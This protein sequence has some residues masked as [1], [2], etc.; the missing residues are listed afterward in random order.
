[1]GPRRK[2]DAVSFCAM[3]RRL[4]FIV[5]LFVLAAAPHLAAAHAVLVDTAPHDGAVLQHAPDALTLRFN[6]PVNPIAVRLFGP[7][8]DAVALPT[9]PRAVD[10]EIR[11]PLPTDLPSGAYLVSFRV[12]SADAHPIGGSF[13]FAIGTADASTSL[14][15]DDKA[16]RED[17]W[18]FATMMNRFVGLLALLAAAG[19]GLCLAL[20]FRG[21]APPGSPIARQI[22]L[23]GAVAIAAS[24]LALGLTGGWLLAGPAASLLDSSTWRLGSAT[25]IGRRAA[26]SILGL[27]LLAAGLARPQRAWGRYLCIA[28][29]LVATCS[30]ALSGHA[31]ALK[32]S[33]PTQAALALHATA[34]AF[35]IGSLGPLRAVVRQMPPREAA[36][37]LH[38]FS[39]LAIPAVALLAFAG[40][41]I[42]IAQIR[43]FDALLD[44]AYGWILLLKL[45]FV[46]M[47]LVLAA[48]NWRTLTPMLAAGNAA[49]IQ[50]LRAAIRT[51]FGFAAVVLL[52]TAILAHTAPGIPAPKD[53]HGHHEAGP[54]VAIT[55]ES[56]GRSLA[57]SV[58][59]ASVGANRIEGRIAGT[60]GALIRP[61]EVHVEFALPE[62]GI[63]PLRWKARIT[64]DG[65]AQLNSVSLPR[66]GLWQARVE[67]LISD[68]EKAVFITAIPIR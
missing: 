59:P 68:F 35:W 48:R 43:T 12:V 5:A 25:P 19:G 2:G 29:A 52:L 41:G 15:R 61:L 24:I 23:G 8:G 17:W 20:V 60:D 66:A 13:M 46:A 4:T 1:M 57:L 34:A 67:A 33:W 7:N 36:C 39:T 54:A 30:I 21:K 53:H 62:A 10:Q 37:A 45:G 50:T 51:E 16:G 38:R 6:E 22:L 56:R 42:A 14:F 9:A 31:A 55:V 63:E 26:A 32:P 65:V 64:D 28:G 49:A 44:T 47:M 40:A 18:Q 27:V 11:Q 58:A 3:L